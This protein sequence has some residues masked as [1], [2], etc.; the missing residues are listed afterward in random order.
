MLATYVSSKASVSPSATIMGANVAI[1]GRSVIG[2]DTVIVGPAVIGFPSRKKLLGG[3]RDLEDLS[4]VST[5]A[6]V[7]SKCVIRSFATIYE[8]VVLGSGVELGHYVLIREGSR[9]GSGTK[10]GT[11]TIID[12]MSEIGRGVSI[13]SGVYI[14]LLTVIEDDVFLGPG[15]V[16]TN[17]RY[18]PSSRI[19]ETRVEK[20]AVVG[21]NTIIIAGVRIGANSVIGAGSVVTKDIPPNTFAYGVPARVV[22]SREYYE[23]K[24]RGY[25]LGKL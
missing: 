19:V 18:P 20:G 16:I 14:P 22:A 1:L 5:G 13:Q 3:G 24:K 7:G 21:A 15:V 10:V 2:D 8:D 6:R 11:G 25:E 9:V 23:D 17:D 12:G 4:S